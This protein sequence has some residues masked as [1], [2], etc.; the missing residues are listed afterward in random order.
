M[1]INLKKLLC[2]SINSIVN[3]ILSFLLKQKNHIEYLIIDLFTTVL[4]KILEN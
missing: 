1:K 4:N 3:I 2:H